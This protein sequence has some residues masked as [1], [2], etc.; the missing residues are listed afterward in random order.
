MQRD[1]SVIVPTY[2]RA[3]L[4]PR[5]LDAIFAQTHAPAEVILVDD[6][7][8]DETAALARDYGDRLRYQ[9]LHETRGV[10]AARNHGIALAHGS[11]IAFCDSDDAWLPRKLERQ[12]EALAVAPELRL[13]HTEEL[14]IRN[15]RRVNQLQK[16]EKAGG[17]IFF[18]CLPRCVISPS[19]ALLAR[20]LLDDV[21][22]FDTSL[23]ACEDYD[24][25]LRICARE[26]V[27]FVDEPLIVK[28][29]GH[30]DQL[31]RH[32]Y[33]IDRFRIRALH[34]LLVCE[35]LT[36]VQRRTTRAMLLRKLDIFLAGAEK[37]RRGPLARC[38]GDELST[39][40]A[41]REHW[42]QCL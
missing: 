22:T 36:T 39:L 30:A 24:L 12:L 1:V 42:R 9:R 23:P 8:S 10:S 21:G 18:R 3:A 20:S 32:F 16:H 2:Q 40:Q 17:D 38:G 27:V 37:R 14:W 19:S 34:R 29:G 6:G 4:L 33:G 31:S 11:W 13:C 7:S 25:W 41:L 28:Y 5:A 26:R 35:K 15:G